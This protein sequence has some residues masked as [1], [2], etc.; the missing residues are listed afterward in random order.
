MAA[1]AADVLCTDLRADAPVVAG[2]RSVYGRHHI[3]DLLQADLVAVAGDSPTFHSAG[4]PQR[5]GSGTE[6]L[7]SPLVLAFGVPTLA[8]T[9]TNGKSSTVWL[10]HQILEQAGLISWV[11]GNLGDPVSSL[12]LRL[13]TG[14]VA[15]A[16][17][18]IEVSSYQLETIE[19]YRPH[20]ARF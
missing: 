2:T 4:R 13:V 16:F 3:D 14:G 17:A 15:P 10:L 6:S 19:R 20:A 1:V 18:V 8:V 7:R 9:G 5:G 11:G 12:A